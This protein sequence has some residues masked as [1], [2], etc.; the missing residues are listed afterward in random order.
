MVPM[1]LTAATVQ[2]S[3]SVTATHVSWAGIELIF[4][5]DLNNDTS[6]A[7]KFLEVVFTVVC[8]HKLT[9]ECFSVKVNAHLPTPI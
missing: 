4:V 3:G 2:F 5:S 9:F 8:I 6:L 7:Y 1:F